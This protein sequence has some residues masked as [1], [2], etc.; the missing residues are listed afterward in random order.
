MY[1][2]YIQLSLGGMELEWEIHQFIEDNLLDSFSN[3]KGIRSITVSI[4][5]GLVFLVRGGSSYHVFWQIYPLSLGATAN[6]LLWLWAVSSALCWIIHQ[7]SS[8][9]RFPWFCEFVYSRIF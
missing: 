3:C 4:C 7:G 6:K 8:A 9:E 2:S 1:Y 5:Y